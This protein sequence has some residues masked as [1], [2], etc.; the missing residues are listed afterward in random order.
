MRQRSKVDYVAAEAKLDDMELSCSESDNDEPKQPQRQP[1]KASP[2]AARGQSAPAA[3]DGSAS[4]SDEGSES[5][6][7][8]LSETDLDEPPSPPARK[9][10]RAAAKKPAAGRAPV[11]RR[12]A[13]GDAMSDEEDSFETEAPRKPKA[14]PTAHGRSG[15]AWEQKHKKKWS[16]DEVDA[17]PV[18]VKP[19]SMFDDMVQRT[20]A[21]AIIR[22]AALEGRSLAA[23]ASE[24]CGRPLRVATMCS[25][26]ESPLL[27]LDMICKALQQQA[28]Q[29]L[30]VEHVFSC[31]IEPF[32]QAYIERN[33]APPLL[34]RDIRELGSEEATTAYGASHVVP[35]GVDVLI[36]GTSCVDYSNMNNK[37]KGIEE[38]GESGQTFWGMLAWVRRHRPPIVLQENVCGAPWDAMVQYYAKEGYAAQYL[39]VDTKNHYIP[40]TRTRVYLLAL[41][42]RAPDRRA[43]AIGGAPAAGGAVV[44]DEQ[45]ARWAASVNELSRPSSASLEA[46]LLPTDDPRVHS[47]REHLSS[48]DVSK[49]RGV[50]DWGRCETRHARARVEEELGTKRPLTTW[51]SQGHCAGP[52]FAWHDWFKTQVERVLDL[53]DINFLRLAARGEDANYKTLVWNLSQNVDRST[54]AVRPGL[55]PCLTP[56]MVPY[57]TNR[58]GPI[59]GPEVLALQGI[60]IDDLLLTRENNDQMADLAGNAMSSTI[61]GTCI[62]SALLLARDTLRAFDAPP[63]ADGGGGGLI[64]ST[65]GGAPPADVASADSVGLREAA[66]ELQAEPLCTPLSELLAQAAGSARM[67]ASEGRTTIAPDVVRCVKCGATASRACCLAWPEHVDMAPVTEP[68]LAPRD[69]EAKLAAAIPMCVRLGGLQSARGMRPDGALLPG[70]VAAKLLSPRARD[71]QEELAKPP[72]DC[73]M[74]LYASKPKGRSPLE[75]KNADAGPAK[76]ATPA[77]KKTSS[78]ADEA[79]WSAWLAAVSALDA[80]SFRFTSATRGEDWSVQYASEAGRLE[81]VLRADGAEW[82]A[83]AE[84]PASRGVLRELLLQPVARMRVPASA[85]GLLDGAWD[86]CLPRV[87]EVALTIASVGAPV[88]SWQA[89]IGLDAEWKTSTRF[90]GWTVGASDADAAHLDVDVRGEYELLDRCGG[91]MNCMH[92]RSGAG[93]PLYLFLDPERTGTADGDRVVFASSAGRM[94]YGSARRTVGTLDASWR[95]WSVGKKQPGA[96]SDTVPCLVRGAWVAASGLALVPL[97]FAGAK[98]AAPAEPPRLALRGSAP[99]GPPAVPL[100]RC[101]V[102]LGDGAAAAGWPAGGWGHLPVGKSKA[103]FE[104]IAWITERLELPAAVRGW[105]A[106]EAAEAVVA[107]HSGASPCEASA[108][109]MPRLRWV[110]NAR[111]Q[112]TALEDPVQ[113][114]AYEQALKR[115]PAPFGVAMRAD[116]AEGGA[117]VGQIEVSANPLALALRALALMPTGGDGAA[118]ELAWRVVPHSDA[119]EP[120]PPLRL[121]SNK[122]DEAAGQPPHFQAFSGRCGRVLPLRPEQQRSLAWMLRQEAPD[123]PPFVEQEVGEAALPALGWRLEARARVPRL[124]RGGVLADEVG[125]GKTVIT[126]ALI[127]ASP[128][129]PLPPPPPLRPSGFH[130]LKATL[131]LAP[132]HLLKQWP[133]E[134]AR[135]TGGAL[136]TLT[137]ATMADINKYSIK[138]LEAAD[139]VVCAIT[140]LRNDLYFE[141]LANLAGADKLPSKSSMRHFAQAYGE[142]MAELQQTV[143]AV[144]SGDVPAASQRVRDGQQRRAAARRGG[145]GHMGKSLGNTANRVEAGLKLESMAMA[146]APQGKKATYAA[147]KKAAAKAKAGGSADAMDVSDGEDDVSPPAKAGKTSKAAAKPAKRAAAGG[148][149]RA[150]P[151]PASD[152]DFEDDEDEQEASEYEEEPSEDEKPAKKRGAGKSKPATADERDP[153]GLSGTK[154]AKDWRHM[155]A[156]PL[157]MFYWNRLVIDE[158]TYNKE[159]DHVA[160]VSGVQAASRWVLSGTPDVSGFPAVAETANWLGLHLGSSDAS[161]LSKQERKEQS[162]LERFQYFKEVH[163]PAWHAQRHAVAQDFLDRYVRQ[164]VAEID[165]IPWREQAALVALPPSERALY[166]ELKNHLEALDMKNSHKTIKSKCK[167][168]NDREARL[169]Q[170]LGG[171]ASPEEALLKRCAHFDMVG[172]AT[173]AAAA[174]NAIVATRTKQLKLCSEEIERQTGYARDAIALFEATHP[175]AKLDPKQAELRGMPASHFRDWQTKEIA[176][177]GDDEATRRMVLLVKAGLA[178]PKAKVALPPEEKSFKDKMAWVR[179]QV[180]LLRRLQKEL[181]GRVRSLRFFEAVRSVQSGGELPGKAAGLPADSLG[182]LSCCGHAGP[183]AEMLEAAD[184]QECPHPRCKAAARP[185]CVV[186]V[187][188]LGREAKSQAGGAFGAKLSAVAALIT[189]VPA[190]ERVLVFVQFADLLVKVQ[191]ALQ[192]AGHKVALLKGTPNQRSATIEAFQQPELAPSQPRVLLLNLRDESAAGANLTAASHCVFLHP[193]L[194]GSQQEFDS[195]DT[196][197]VGRVRRYGQARTVQ[198]YRFVVDNTIDTDIFRARRADAAPMLEAACRADEAA[199]LP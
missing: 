110:A 198:I 58:G 18:L 145:G 49:Q 33:F 114:G 12:P 107:W 190:G 41:D 31:E 42:T 15:S 102:P 165:E 134:I 40:H 67:C 82:L 122:Q 131:V 180:H 23:L 97:S 65:G 161:E 136:K 115:R 43:A 98:V 71:E 112:V 149:K 94:G 127:D 20:E 148:R 6:D 140:V 106:L 25:G 130:P 9:G 95:P 177:C 171:S 59:V 160:I 175:T 74:D 119:K 93:P 147:E 38:K 191:E 50:V 64:N 135:F 92:K 195:C 75:P 86:F 96:R 117:T 178:R 17:L 3:S 170:V 83:Y 116:P 77:R 76:L 111:G 21:Q 8:S 128:R 123:A 182:L 26:T 158:F 80:G 168:E 118:A 30:R 91:A 44:G 184:R 48:A 47:A 37:Q 27:A 120:R 155:T 72:A 54:G 146:A 85:A 5:E 174:C 132:S 2:A 129:A 162:A 79:L 138:Q 19:Q 36:A 1:R 32:K 142:T 14:K 70:G 181:T 78:P 105:T 199:P 169:A 63:P 13:D 51:E 196:Q 69:F 151:S 61:V 186:R 157:E 34:F 35:G 103:R 108:P 166:I 125:Y 56:N 139:V 144:T 109:S 87:R 11:A 88:E 137:I 53:M 66:L 189:R 183:L 194:V 46:F 163:T 150:A 188:E 4:G 90:R 126:I 16:S 62:L 57:L 73:P 60:P 7:G 156:A 81:L 100:L 179:D 164:N 185:G 153:W 197:A 28:G 89:S 141:R 176:D 113:A 52:D 172:S 143:A 24:L 29:S 192:A 154:C 10:G 152:D 22:G 101:E 104:S 121:S 99:D 159:R 124:V 133:S 84:A 68:R 173:S 193:L 187:S 55:C 39:R 45:L 167:S